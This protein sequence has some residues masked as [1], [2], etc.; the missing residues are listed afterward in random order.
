MCIW[1]LDGGLPLGRIFFG[2]ARLCIFGLV[3][4]TLGN[5]FSIEL[6]RAVLKQAPFLSGGVQ[7]VICLRGRVLRSYLQ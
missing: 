4:E 6:M 7:F 5:G 1:S 2:L 3:T